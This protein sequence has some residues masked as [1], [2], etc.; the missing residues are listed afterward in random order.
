MVDTNNQQHAQSIR[1][2]LEGFGGMAR[3]L[4]EGT[5]HSLWPPDKG[6]VLRELNPNSLFKRGGLEAHKSPPLKPTVK[7]YSRS[8]HQDC[9]N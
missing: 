8:D 9:S 3:I 7:N 2:S 6:N 4:R 1:R 5:K